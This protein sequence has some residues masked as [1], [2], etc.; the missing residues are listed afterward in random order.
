MTTR[1]DGVYDGIPDTEYHADTRSL[2]SSGA[3][4]ILKSAAQF[5]YDQDHPRPPKKEFD[6]G[7][8][9]HSLVLG[10]GAEL[11]EIPE[12]LL[13]SNG[14]ASTTAAKEF[15][16]EARVDG[17][18]ALKPDDYRKVK[19]MAAA[20]TDNPFARQLLE[21]PGRPEQSIYWTDPDTGVRLRARPDWLTR[22]NGRQFI[23]DYKSTVDSA[24][25]VFEQ[26]AA[27]F[28]YH[29]QDPWYRDAVIAA[30]ID[31][32]PEFLFIAQ[33]KTPPYLV[34]VTRFDPESV[35]YGRRRNRRAINLF[36]Q[37]TRTNTW[38]GHV[39][40]VYQISIPRWAITEEEE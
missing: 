40:D 10:V 38:P 2:S 35:N 1:P 33:S 19:A 28:G 21:S 18:V 5:R 26:H 20:I 17:A 3:R 29:C 6:F 30:G 36:D 27:S 37:C 34:S 22:T 14:A 25:P 13:A 24:P 7:H 32:N 23:A 12:P 11:R 39:T 9:A 8:A 4:A 16:N 15:I 31:D